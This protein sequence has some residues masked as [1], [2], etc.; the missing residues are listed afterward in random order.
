M[1]SATEKRIDAKIVDVTPDTLANYGI[2][3]YKD[4]KKQ[5]E[6]RRK[7]EWYRTYHPKGLRIKVVVP[8]SVVTRA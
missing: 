6:L 1:S 8:K 4:V 5:L 2:C 3:G 7:I